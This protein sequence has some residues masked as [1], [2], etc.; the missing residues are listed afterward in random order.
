MASIKADIE[1]ASINAPPGILPPDT[2]F[3]SYIGHNVINISNYEL[4][5]HQVSALEKG[6]TFC[7]TPKGPDKSEIWNDF[8][9][10]HRRLELMQFIRPQDDQNNLMVSQ[11]IIDFMN[12][13]AS[14][15]IQEEP[16][17]DPYKSIHKHFNNKSSWRPNPPNKTLDAFKRAF[18]MNLLKDT[19]H[20]RPIPNLSKDQWKGLLNLR[21]NPHIVIKKADKGSAIVIMNTIDYLR[22]GYRQLN[23]SNFYTK[24]KKDPTQKIS[25]FV[26]HSQKWRTVNLSLRKILTFWTSKIQRLVD[27]TNYLKSTKNR[28]QEDRS[29]AP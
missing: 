23:D 20:K 2:T 15:D 4:N 8:K 11:S 19:V 24:L 7:P 17:N 29:V 12:E 18:K 10:F 14:S 9:E 16:N 21:N 28:S 3:E 26:R 25:K 1:L 6:L 27:F 13:N 22:E 5:E